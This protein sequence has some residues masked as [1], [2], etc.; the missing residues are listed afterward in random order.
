MLVNALLLGVAW[1]ALSAVIFD[2]LVSVGAAT[3]SSMFSSASN[4]PGLVMTGVIGAVQT[5]S[6][7]TAMLLAEAGVGVLAMLVFVAVARVWR[8]SPGKVVHG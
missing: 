2:L 1:A 3:V 7:S 4:V 8:E 5:R 6:G